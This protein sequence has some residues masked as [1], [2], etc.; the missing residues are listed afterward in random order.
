MKTM[1]RFYAQMN[2]FTA[3]LIIGVAVFVVV[4]VVISN[5]D[6]VGDYYF[7][8][9][10]FLANSMMVSSPRAKSASVCWML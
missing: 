4:L 9:N 6:V 5:R 3:T 7:C 2:P 8:F 10:S 1:T